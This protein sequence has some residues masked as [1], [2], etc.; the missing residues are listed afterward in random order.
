MCGLTGFLET[1]PEHL[2]ESEARVRSMLATLR[3]RGPDDEGT[4]VDA[5]GAVLGLRRLAIIDLSELGH[6]PMTSQDGRYVLAFNGEIYDHERL[7]D[8]L[9]GLGHRFRGG[10]DTEVLVAA[11]QQWGFERTLAEVNGMFAV[12]VW[13][14]RDRSLH[15]AR[16][17]FGEKPLYYG[18]AGSA[19][20]F[21]SELKAIRAHPAFRAEIDRDAL[22]LLLRF[23]YIP[24]PWSIFVGIRKLLPGTHLRIPCPTDVGELPDPLPYWSLATVV[25]AAKSDPFRGSFEDAVD[26][27]EA[28]LRESVELRMVADVPL[29]A[30]LSGGVDSSMIVALMQSLGVRPVKTFTVG[31]E[32]P[33]YDE[34]RFAR[35]VAEHLG[36]EHTELI[37]TDSDARDVIPR[38]PG[39]YDEPFAD[40]SQ[41]PAFLVSSLAAEQLTVSL[42]GDGGDEVFGG[43]NRYV[44]IDRLQR[45]L[46]VLPPGAR[47]FLATCLTAIPPER[48][49]RMTDRFAWLRRGEAMQRPGDKLQKLAGVVSLDDLSEAYRRLVTHWEEPA[50]VVI[51]ATEPDAFAIAVDRSPTRELDAVDG[52]MFLDSLTYLPDDILA[53]VDR[54]SMGVSLEARVPYLDPR[55]VEF[56]WRLPREFKI[57]DGHGKWILRRVL[58]R[59]VPPRL[60]ERPKAGFGVPISDWLRG[61]LR[62]WADDLLSEQRLRGQGLLDA[63]VVR[64]RWAE[65]LNGRRNWQYHIWDVLML[66]AWLDAEPQQLVV[67]SVGHA[68]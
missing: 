21:G 5:S 43:Y 7:R 14:R 62:P 41:I 13:D 47:R 61:P 25:D 1:R 63:D 9:R 27:L 45:R 57:R 35:G 30:F 58:A 42:S 52:A 19:F 46:G 67:G 40:S 33:G 20:V 22:S 18:W 24:A 3:H 49:N 6:Q 29:G 4:W 28:L 65:H 68:R 36:T 59:H 64:R 56:A 48:V 31:S 53:K 37:V 23:K 15:L 54:A 32:V 2:S 39:L 34:A 8:R 66:Q 10:S 17:R 44:W 51:G 60:T 38:L 50:S 12:A 26:E 11:V 16:D 55:V